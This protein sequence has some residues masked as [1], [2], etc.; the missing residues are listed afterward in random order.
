MITEHM[1]KHL[2][3]KCFVAN[4]LKSEN[5]NIDDWVDPWRQI[6]LLAERGDPPYLGYSPLLY[7]LETVAKDRDQARLWRAEIDDAAERCSAR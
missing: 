4:E 5:V 1:Q 3:H 2:L 7:A 6:L